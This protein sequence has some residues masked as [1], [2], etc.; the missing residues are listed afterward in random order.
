MAINV[1]G[2]SG[3]MSPVHKVHI[4]FRGAEECFH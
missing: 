2:P 1:I 3:P 4:S